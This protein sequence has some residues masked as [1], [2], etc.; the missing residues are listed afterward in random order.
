MHIGMES[1]VVLPPFRTKLAPWRSRRLLPQCAEK[2]SQAGS[3]TPG[4]SQSGHAGRLAKSRGKDHI[5]T[6]PR[7]TTQIHFRAHRFSLNATASPTMAP[8]CLR[9]GRTLYI[10]EKMDDGTDDAEGLPD[11]RRS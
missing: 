9:F 7:I 6:Q 11:P 3:L 2:V 4:D 10:E 1:A 8:V 5:H